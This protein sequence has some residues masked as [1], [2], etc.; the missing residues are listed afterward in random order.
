M[1]SS[2]KGKGAIVPGG[3]QGIGRALV[4]ALS[5]EGT[6]V[7]LSLIHISEHTRLGMI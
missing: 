5:R 6:A 2:L 3:A 1:R 4:L 7:V